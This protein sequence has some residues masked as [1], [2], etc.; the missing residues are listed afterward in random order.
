[1]RL[2]ININF[3]FKSP[4]G[5]GQINELLD[6]SLTSRGS[7]CFVHRHSCFYNTFSLVFT[8]FDHGTVA[9]KAEVCEK[10]DSEKQ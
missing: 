10:G 8:A 9:D 2:Y 5:K 3:F 7:V 1:M 4:L 6:F